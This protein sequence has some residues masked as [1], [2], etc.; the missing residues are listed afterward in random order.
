MLV[1]ASVLSVQLVLSV[2]V[3]LHQWRVL[4][5]TGLLRVLPPVRHA[6]QITS[7]RPTVSH[8]RNAC[9]VSI[10]T[11]M[12]VPR[13]QLEIT[14]TTRQLAVVRLPVLQARTQKP[15][16]SHAHHA[17]VGTPVQ[18]VY[19]VQLVWLASTVLQA[20]T[21]VSTVPPTT[22]VQCWTPVSMSV[23][24]AT[25]VTPLNKQPAQHVRWA[26]IVLEA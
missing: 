4:A 16:L 24:R 14:V 13:V 20:A 21:P 23:Q 19:W 2:L 1:T 9:L 5:L 6:L 15:V 10:S 7:V 18:V 17:Q 12:L 26:S 3:E 22:T 25:T 11:E 8:L